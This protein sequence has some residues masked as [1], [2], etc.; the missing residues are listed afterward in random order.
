MIFIRSVDRSQ[1]VYYSMVARGFQGEFPD[2]QKLSLRIRDVITASSFVLFML[3]IRLSNQ[4][5][6][7]LVLN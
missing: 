5:I 7:E 1:T 2:F 3:I 4:T 6:K